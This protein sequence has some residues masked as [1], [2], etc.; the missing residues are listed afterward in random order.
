METQLTLREILAR[1]G[2]ESSSARDKR[3]RLEQFGMV[4]REL[5]GSEAAAALAYYFEQAPSS[6]AEPVTPNL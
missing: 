4:A 1:Q 5:S 6:C 3:K 2:I